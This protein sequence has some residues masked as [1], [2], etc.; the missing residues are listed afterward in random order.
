MFPKGDEMEG[1][2]NFEIENYWNKLKRRHCDPIAQLTLDSYVE[3]YVTSQNNIH[4]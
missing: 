3:K 1:K 2:D 4:H